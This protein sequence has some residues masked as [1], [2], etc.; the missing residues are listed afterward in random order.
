LRLTLPFAVAMALV[1]AASCTFVYV[2][3][4]ATLLKSVD[5]G[6]RSQASDASTRLAAGK[7]LL[8]RDSLDSAEIA[9]LLSPNGKVVESSPPGVAPLITPAIDQRARARALT[10]SSEISSRKNTWRLRAI[11][12][13]HGRVIVVGR[14]LESRDESLDRLRHEFIFS[15]PLALLV[16]TLAGYLLAGAALRP[17]EAMRRRA[18]AISA[19]TPG[20]RL[21]VPAARDEISRLAETIN[22]MLD[23][24]EAAFAHE[25]RFVSDASH[26]LRTPLALLR[27]ELEL[28]LR[29]TRT[30][31]ELEAAVRSAA[32]ETDRLSSL[33]ED[34]LLVARA[35]Q[36]ALPVHPEHVRSRAL[37]DRV[38]E[39]FASRAGQLGRDVRVAGEDVP[40]DADP[41]R[42]EQALGNLVANAL[43]HG[44]GTVEL[45][46][47]RSNGHVELH[48]TDEGSGLPAGFAARAFD[49]F[50]RADDARGRGGSGLGL[51]IVDAIAVAHGGKAGVDRSECGGA[52]VWIAI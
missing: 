18:A 40:F 51:A 35:D 25:R 11:P 42:L 48:V 45:S 14:S 32:E 12:A 33:A 2:R 5:Q 27:T 37:F 21:P 19:S 29:R 24:L 3:V 36:G 4:G 20:A 38:A 16:A 28:A 47:R 26:E 10:I 50:S 23:R 46:A 13:A 49:R 15:A 7:T 39:R 43:V 6:L 34:L 1:L 22:A 31:E 44:A 17:V 52:D 9:Q 30:H 41:A 8:D